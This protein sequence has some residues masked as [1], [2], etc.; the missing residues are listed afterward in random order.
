MTDSQ[1]PAPAAPLQFETAELPDSESAR[2]CGACK[3]PLRDSYFD[4]NGT[5]MCPSCKEQ[6]LAQLQGGSG[7]ARVLKAG[8][9]GVGA[10]IAGAAVYGAITTASGYNIGLISIAVG[11]LV[12]TAV[13]KG[14]EHRG[15]PGYQVLA[16]VFTYLAIGASMIPEVVKAADADASGVAKVIM[17]VVVTFIGPVLQAT[18]SPLSG[19][20]Y[21]FG[22]WE[23][24]KLTKR[25]VI[26]VSG[27]YQVAAP[28]AA[29]PATVEAVQ[30]E[31]P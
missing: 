26:S 13:A 17:S 29:A 21:A 9:F 16:F 1:T 30:A 10:A 27:P 14:S 8:L 4:V 11:W 28:E 6:V 22:L 23:A 19:L 3:Q 24:I 15:G 2:P 31:V 25:R 20:I 18:E 7:F 12:G 5:V